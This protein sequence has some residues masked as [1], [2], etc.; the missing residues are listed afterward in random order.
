[1]LW[2]GTHHVAPHFFGHPLHI[3]THAHNNCCEETLQFQAQ[4]PEMQHCEF[5]FSGGIDLPMLENSLPRAA[6]LIFHFTALQQP[7]KK[8]IQFN[9]MARAPPAFI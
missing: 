1:M 5:C 7:S 8:Q 6:Q 9:Q 4:P 3:Q 2:F